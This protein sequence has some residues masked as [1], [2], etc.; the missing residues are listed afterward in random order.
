[1]IKKWF[2][3]IMD[4]RVNLQ[5]RMFRLTTPIGISALLLLLLLKLLLGV[6]EPYLLGILIY[7]AAISIVFGISTHH[8]KTY[9]GAV[10][11]SAITAFLAL[12]AIFFASGGMYSGVPSW[13]VYFF[14][15][16]CLV[17][18]G[19]EGVIFLL[20]SGGMLIGCNYL[21]YCNPDYLA[22]PNL[23]VAYTDSAGSSILVSAVIGVMIFFQNRIYR[24]ENRLAKE[25]KEEIKALNQ[26]QNRFF[27]SMSHEI[28]TPINTIIGLNE[29]ILR[30]DIS[31]EIAEDAKN[32]Q[33]ASKMLLTLIN[34][35]LD[36]SKIESGKMDI[37]PVEYETGVFFSDIVNMIWVRAKEKGLE[38]H[39]SI[40]PSM[41]SMLFGDE[42]RI[43]QVLINLLN[44]SIKYTKEG[45][46][47]LTVGCHSLAPNRVMVSYEIS[48]TGMGIKKENIP[49]LF[50]AFQRV[51]EKKNRYIEG[52]GLGLSIVK[53]LVDLMG[54]EIKVNSVYTKGSTFL[55]TLEQEIIDGR[56]IGEVSLESKIRQGSRE[57]YKKRFTAPD[58]RV[59]VVDDNE[60]NL[61]VAKKLLSDTQ[62]QVDTAASGPECLKLTQNTPYDG[63]L[64]DHLM[65]EMD[66][67]ECLHALRSQPGGLCRETPAIALTAN[68]G[69]DMQ[70]LYKREGFAGYLAKPVSGSLLEAAVLKLLPAEKVRILDDSLRQDG[71]EGFLLKNRKQR[72][73]L[74]ITTDSVCDIPK[75]LAE[76]YH[77]PILPYYVHTDKGYF[78]DGEE[79]ESDDLLLYLSADGTA[80]SEAPSVSD[81]EE[82]FAQR[83][84][85]AQDIIH[86]SMARYASKGYD[87]AAAAA[88]C[89]ENVTVFDSGHLSSGM[90]L[91]VLCAMHMTSMEFS[92][93]ELL[94]ELTGLRNRI[95]SSFIVD[96]T[97]TLYNAGKIPQ[98]VQQVCDTMMLRPVLVLKKSKLTVGAVNIGE[99]EHAMR[100]YIR[101]TLKDKKTID[102]SILFITYAGMDGETLNTIKK[103]VLKECDFER[104]Y[105]QKASP[106]IS[107]NCGA[108]T[109]GLLFMR[110]KPEGG[111]L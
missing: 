89:F 49:H 111:V 85:E 73:P 92:K 90:G 107:C 20:F 46:I 77:I 3:P 53:Q 43:K 52:T 99:P 79:V 80:S 47:A 64:M 81:Y 96:N 27:S 62:I 28:R 25:Q 67:I 11:V 40:D 35:I 60:M 63:I 72:I 106:T 97:K 48:D 54:G 6:W 37:I 88:E 2:S 110:K 18:P 68:A 71:E 83:L 14:V 4:H 104:I 108:G 76:Q 61:L 10:I 102:K 70:Q 13:F 82:F 66:G 44:N 93:E 101:Q 100:N 17:L 1:M 59:L 56:E 26:A 19:W 42:V 55:V 78:L 36:L 65:P 29:M 31:D 51:D 50:E 34:D 15:Y 33:G 12:P 58:A 86:V 32:I 5:E 87:N 22:Q 30:G 105:V 74:L 23:L 109:F 91:F 9:I 45:S 39:L 75:E 95:S 38:F 21:A 41:P 84:T 69:G 57:Q 103:L 16:V 8:H 7:L 24:E 94:E 98:I